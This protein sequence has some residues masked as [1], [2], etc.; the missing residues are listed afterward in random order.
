MK[1]GI[2][3]TGI[4]PD[5]LLDDFGSYAEMI[6]SLLRPE[7]GNVTFETYDVREDSFPLSASRCDAW[8]I[9]GS[10]FSAY[11]DLPWIHRLKEL[12]REIRA[13]RLPMVGICFGHQVIAEALGGQVQQSANGWGLGLHQ[14]Q[15]ASQWQQGTGLPG[16]LTLNAFHRDQVVLKPADAEVVAR[17]DFCPYA[18]LA[19]GDRILSLQAHPEFSIAYEYQLI[20]LRKGQAV[21]EEAA[22][23]G[24]ASLRQAGSATDSA[25]VAAWLGRFLKGG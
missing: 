9:S 1:I 3:A 5:E 10:K 6:V 11:E 15:V 2:L 4:T 16:S 14:Y 12:I 23:Q 24:L 20:A 8:V 22:E 7:M 21:P 18:A 25:A 17:S 13:L 19:Y